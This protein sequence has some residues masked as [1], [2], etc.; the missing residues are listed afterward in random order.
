MCVGHLLGVA[1]SWVVQ[2]IVE[3]YRCLIR[4]PV[5]VENDN[6]DRTE[7]IQLLGKKVHCTT[8]KCGASL[9]FASIGAGIGALFH[10]STG[11]WIGKQLK[12]SL[13]IDL[14]ILVNKRPSPVLNDLP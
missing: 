7:K 8:V 6:A 11:Q 10:P 2:I 13:F 1:A 14:F 12:P 9:V 3:T 5:N 4:K